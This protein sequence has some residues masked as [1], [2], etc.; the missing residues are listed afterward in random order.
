MAV[1][2]HPGKKEIQ[3]QLKSAATTC[4]SRLAPFQGTL[5]LLVLILL[6]YKI[7]TLPSTSTH[8]AKTEKQSMRGH[9]WSSSHMQSSK[10][11]S[12]T[13][14]S[15]SSSGNKDATVSRTH[16][17]DEELLQSTSYRRRNR[18]SQQVPDTAPSTGPPPIPFMQMP[19]ACPTWMAEYA[20]FHK[21]HRGEPGAKYLV[22]SVCPGY[23]GLGDRIRAMM[24]VTRLAVS[25]QRVVLFTWKGEPHEPHR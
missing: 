20:A 7:L 11:A 18:S 23:S 5:L 22:Y 1:H 17:S 2:Q 8:Q 21:K 9:A 14:T 3:M 10:N 4:R 6:V 24:Y 25:L 12:H 19:T 13:N 16:A 15:T